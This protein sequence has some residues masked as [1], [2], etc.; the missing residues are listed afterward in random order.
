MHLCMRIHLA[1]APS[2]APAQLGDFGLSRML[3]AEESHVDTQVR[4]PCSLCVIRRCL[5]SALLLCGGLCWALLLPLALP[6][7]CWMR[8]AARRREA[9]NSLH[10]ALGWPTHTPLLLPPLPVC[11][12]QS[13]GTASYA[14]P[15]LLTQGKLTKA[16]DVFSLGIISECFFV[17]T[18]CFAQTPRARAR[19]TGLRPHGWCAACLPPA[20]MVPHPPVM[21]PHPPAHPAPLLSLTLPALQCG[22]S[23]PAARSCTLA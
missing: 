2:S 13:Y 12:P 4:L 5:C 8:V 7:G 19:L 18:K 21:V 11:P 14:A 17:E 22:R 23:C 3:G 6:G 9:Q 1:R 10:S 15:E 16:A 20:V